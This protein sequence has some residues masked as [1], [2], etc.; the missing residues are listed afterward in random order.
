MAQWLVE[1]GISHE[2]Q[3]RYCKSGWLESIGGGAF[4]RPADT[5]QWQGGLYALQHQAKLAV[6]AGGPTALALLG[7]S[8]YLRLGEETVF[9]FSSQKAHI[10]KWFQEYPWGHP[11]QQIKTNV[12]SAGLGT[13]AYA[14]A[15]F[16]VEISSAERSFLECLY[17]APK[18][19][20]FVECYQILEGLI[21]L[22]PKLLQE[23]L[24]SCGSLKVKRLFLYMSEKLQHPWFPFLDKSALNLGSG[25]RS[26][27]PG[28]VYIPQ[29]QIMI[30]KELAEL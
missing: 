4:K 6:H 16:E 20:S 28:G 27:V 22:R 30:P 25:P 18:Y 9:L 11:V 29:Y 12:F 26:F 7:R 15:N 14:E 8:H 19:I 21:D 17:L 10:P 2:L 13:L 23:L 1:Q 3:K 24:E 5:I